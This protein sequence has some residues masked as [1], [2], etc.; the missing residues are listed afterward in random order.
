MHCA[1][2][3]H[4][5]IRQHHRRSAVFRTHALRR[6]LH[7]KHYPPPAGAAI[8]ACL[9][10]A[11]AHHQTARRCRPSLRR[12]IS[13]M[14]TAPWPPSVPPASSPP[15]PAVPR[16]PLSAAGQFRFPCLACVR[17]R[18]QH[19]LSSLSLSLSLSLSWH[20]THAT[21]CER[22]PK[23]ANACER[24]RSHASALLPPALLSP[25]AGAS[26][27]PPPDFPLTARRP[28]RTVFRNACPSRPPA[29]KRQNKKAHENVTFSWAF[30]VSH[31]R[32][33]L[34]TP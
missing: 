32:F 14:H 17:A 20:R 12:A 1:V 23:N 26:S 31:R 21:A 4:C 19:A 18:A 28:A 11:A 9:H 8:L 13:R 24:M 34:R 15:A 6:A 7:H 16:T 25:R 5:T 29:A 27:R 30:L 22:I 33:E 10:R 3:F 2:N